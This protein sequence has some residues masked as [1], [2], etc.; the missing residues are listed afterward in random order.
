MKTIYKIDGTKQPDLERGL[1]R[2]GLV[3]ISFN[4]PL[5]E[6]E[7]VYLVDSQSPQDKRSLENGDTTFSIKRKAAFSNRYGTVTLIDHDLVKVQKVKSDPLVIIDENIPNTLSS[8]VREIL[9]EEVKV[10]IIKSVLSSVESED[11]K[12]SVMDLAR[13]TGEEPEV[14]YNNCVNAITQSCVNGIKRLGIAPMKSA[15]V[16][17][18]GRS[19]GIY[20]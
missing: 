19:E 9:E 12:T 14:V 1:M 10:D 18:Q 17:S 4:E 20:I 5:S 6:E 11:F 13:I 8:C 16:E 3:P 7:I 15:R 2:V